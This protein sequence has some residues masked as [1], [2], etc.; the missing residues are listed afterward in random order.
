MKP[1]KNR[2]YCPECH[3]T[4]MLF[5]S[6]DMTNWE[7]VSTIDSCNRQYGKMWG[8]SYKRT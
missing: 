3:R 6:E 8:C 1:T 4:K 7:Y 5:E 2:V